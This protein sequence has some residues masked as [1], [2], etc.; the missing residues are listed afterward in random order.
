MLL[1]TRLTMPVW[2][3]LNSDDE[4]GSECSRSA[5]LSH[6]REI[7]GVVVLEPRAGYPWGVQDARKGVGTTVCECLGFPAHS[8]WTRPAQRGRNLAARSSAH[9]LLR[10]R[11]GDH[12]ECRGDWRGTRSNVGAAEAW[13]E[14]CC[15]HCQCRSMPAHERRFVLCGL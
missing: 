6:W 14:F 9:R 1:D 2:F 4:T 12:G 3:F 8:G 7:E 10:T 15:P 13:A 5:H 11:L